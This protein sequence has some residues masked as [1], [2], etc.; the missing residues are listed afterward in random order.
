MDNNLINE[1]IQWLK[2]TGRMK[3]ELIDVIVNDDGN[4]Q[5]EK[6]MAWV[7]HNTPNDW[8]EFCQDTNRKYE[9]I[10]QSF[11]YILNCNKTWN[12]Y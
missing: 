10:T 9:G 11:S 7:T 6:K 12:L 3:H 2:D 4:I 5:T 1:Y 8:K